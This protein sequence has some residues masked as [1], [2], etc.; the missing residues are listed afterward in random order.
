MN[1]T[2]STVKFPKIFAIAPPALA[3]TSFT[4]LEVRANARVREWAILVG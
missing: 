1:G 2:N 4:A 3:D